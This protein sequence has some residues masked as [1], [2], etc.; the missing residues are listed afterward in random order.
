MSRAV[1]T[2]LVSVSLAVVAA[3]TPSL[4]DRSSP[5]PATEL[6]VFAAASLTVPLEAVKATYESRHLGVRLTVAFDSSA[7]LRTQIE[8][9][10]PA[11]LFLSADLSNAQVLVDARWTTGPVTPFA[12]NRLAI[13]VPTANPGSIERPVDL[14]RPG[15]R[16]V[17]AGEKV[18]ISLYATELIERLGALP[19]Y[20][21][22]FAAAYEGNI[23]SREDSVRSVVTKVELGEGDAGV[24]YETDALASAGVRA[25]EIPPE[26]VVTATYGGVVMAASS[27]I[28]AAAAF[29]GWLVGPEGQATLSGFGFVELG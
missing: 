18:P 4:A 9:G 6:T 14:A 10:A 27:D 22:G 17:A 11:D 24:V 23:V 19:G 7:A 2:S 28:D 25:I 26:A 20:P 12:G 16:I 29:L 15:L 8:Q 21:A 3:C 13:V 1:V 5:R